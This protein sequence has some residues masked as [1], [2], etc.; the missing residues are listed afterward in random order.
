MRETDLLVIGGGAAGMTAA[1]TGSLCGLRTILFEHSDQVGGTSARS[2][3]TLWIPGNRFMTPDDAAHDVAQARVY[4]DSLVGDRSP[5]ALREA[6]LEQ[7]PPMLE[8]L[9][10]KTSIRF[11]PCPYHS[12]YHP[13]LPG[14]RPGHRPVEPELFDARRLGND[15]QLLREPIREFMVFG[16]MM[17]SKADINLLLAAFRQWEGFKHALRLG[18]RYLGDRISYPRGTR[19][20]MG[21]ALC[22]ALL[23]ECLKNQVRILTR[24]KVQTIEPAGGGAHRVQYSGDGEVNQL[25]VRFGIVFAGGGFSGNAGWREQQMPAPSPRHTAAFE[26]ADASS[27]SLALSL[28]AS[29]GPSRQDNAWWF[30]SSVLRR[31]NGQTGVF[32][33]IIM[34]RAKPGLIAVDRTGRRFAN[35]GLSYHQFARAQYANDAIPCWLI[36]DAAFMRR[37][38]MGAVRPGGAGLRHALRS[39]YVMSAPDLPALAAQI[40]VDAV[41]LTDSAARMNRFARGGV[42]E[43]FGK[44]SDKLSR[45]NGDPSTSRPNPCLG[46]VEKPPFYAI[47]VWPADLGTSRGLLTDSQARILD[48]KR[49]PIAGLYACGNDMQSVM[50]GQYP[51]PGVT[52][53]PG[54]TFAYVAARDS[55]ARASQQ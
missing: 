50:G 47:Q 3:G 1:L 45:Q 38:G 34:D 40:G 10:D 33:H 23:Y 15:F 42:D 24:T 7:G 16:G 31:P 20:T 30:P 19:L 55:Q 6:F 49:N 26:G 32:P 41:G 22:G 4:L 46:P 2:A 25:S 44:G 18:A 43:D 14:A 9:T 5:A 29:L 21:N 36:C 17:V 48:D 52:L 8:F 13:D 11:K 28:G 37:Y 39:G 51:A 54:M 27:L 35:E 12:D 53:G